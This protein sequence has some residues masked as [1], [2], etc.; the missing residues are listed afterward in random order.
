MYQDP[1]LSHRFS[2]KIS[3][4]EAVGMENGYL[5]V[6]PIT[7]PFKPLEAKHCPM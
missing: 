4:E 1:E 3:S 6:I 2:A 7:L 5:S